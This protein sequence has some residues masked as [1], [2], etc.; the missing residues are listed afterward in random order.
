MS[1]Q[2][3]RNPSGEV[4]LWVKDA[5]CSSIITAAAGWHTLLMRCY[6]HEEGFYHYG[7]HLEEGHNIEGF[8]SVQLSLQAALQICA[9]NPGA[10]VSVSV[11]VLTLCW[12]DQL[13]CRGRVIVIQQ[14]K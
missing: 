5:N 13:E 2:G 1:W 12:Q 3:D 4:T 9:A 7:G 11:S 14:G 8:E 10:S 6:E